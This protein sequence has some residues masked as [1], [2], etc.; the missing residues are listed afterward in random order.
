MFL[1]STFSAGQ[2]PFLP[3]MSPGQW[4]DHVERKRYED[5]AVVQDVEG[6]IEYVKKISR[7]TLVCPP[8]ATMLEDWLRSLLDWSPE[9][10]GKSG[11]Q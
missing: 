9:T 2:R 1:T 5:I 3:N 11:G 8:L 10:R 4:L 7:E 6:K